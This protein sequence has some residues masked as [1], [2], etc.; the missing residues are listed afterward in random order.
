MTLLFEELSYAIRGCAMEVRK[1]YGPGHK[2]IR[3]QG[4]EKCP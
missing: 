3:A 1:D 2:G 4:T